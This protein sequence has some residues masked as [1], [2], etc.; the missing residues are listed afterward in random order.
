MRASLLAARPVRAA[1]VGAIHAAVRR[2][3]DDGVDALRL[4]RR[5][6]DADASRLRGQTVAG[7]LGPV[8]AAVGRLEQAAARAV[9]RRI[10]APRRAPRLPERGVDHVRIARLEGE[11]D[12]AGVAVVRRATRMLLPRRA[13]VARTEDAA[14]RVRPVRMAERRDVDE[15]RIRRMDDD[16]S[17]LLRVGRGRC[18]TTSCR[19]RTTCT[20]RC[21]ARCRS[22]CRP[23]RCRRRSRADSTAPPRSRRSIRSAARRRSAATCGRRRASPTRRRSRCRSRNAP[24][25]PERR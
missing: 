25:R 9:R 15:V 1:V 8:I 24:A 13:A 5:D 23:R 7:E 2:G 19:R 11:V 12:R 18:A 10:D 14:L 4:R 6:G 21:P 17:D 20:C 3:I 16:A 22:A